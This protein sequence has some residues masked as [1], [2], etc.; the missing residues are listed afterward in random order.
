MIIKL[1]YEDDLLPVL[2]NTDYIIAVDS[3]DQGSLVLIKDLNGG[4][5]VVESPEEIYNLCTKI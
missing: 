1:R 2:V 4:I 5:A 3:R